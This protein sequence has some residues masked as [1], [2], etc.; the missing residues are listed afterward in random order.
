MMTLRGIGEL[1]E[2]HDGWDEGGRQLVKGC[3][4]GG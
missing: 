3:D 2:E 1:R 4:G